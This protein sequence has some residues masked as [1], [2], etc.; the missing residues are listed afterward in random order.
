M[1][2]KGSKNLSGVQNYSS[3]PIHFPGLPN[4]DSVQAAGS[5]NASY[6]RL[7]LTPLDVSLHFPKY[8]FVVAM[9]CAGIVGIVMVDEGSVRNSV[10]G[11]RIRS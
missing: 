6:L 3:G 7:T 9:G 5:L 1:D 2:G 11:A 10:C 4:F 8:T